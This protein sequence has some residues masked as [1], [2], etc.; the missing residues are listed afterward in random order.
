MKARFQERLVRFQEEWEEERARSL[1]IGW[2]RVGTFVAGLSGYVVADVTTGV[3]SRTAWV[4][5]VLVSAAFLL[6]VVWHRRIRRKEK[7]L[8]GLVQANGQAL[9]R[10]DRDWTTLPDSPLEPPSAQHPYALDLDVS[11]PGSLFSLLSTVTLPPGQT[12]LREWLLAPAS[13]DEIRRRQEGVGELAPQLDLRQELEVTGRGVTPPGPAAVDRF[14]DWAEGPSWL[15]EHLAIRVGAWVL[16]ILNLCLVGM[17]VWG[18]VARP[19]WLFSVGMTF[20]VAGIHRK[21]IH[22]IMHAAASGQ[23]GLEPYADLLEILRDMDV[24]API[25]QELRDLARSG[26]GGGPGEL[27]RLEKKIGWANVRENLLVHGPF[28]GLFAWD[29]HALSG[30]EGWKDRSGAHVRGWLH[31]LGQL[32]ALSAL[33]ALKGEHPEWTFPR[34]E[35][36][37]PPGLWARGLGHP[38]LPPDRCVVN[39]VSI[40]PPGG[41]LF[42]T[43]SNMSGKSTLLRAVGL[44]V[45]LAQA[46][47]PV[48]AREMR[49]TPLDVETSMRTAD[50]LAQGVSQYMAE[51]RRIE[52]VVRAARRRGGSGGTSDVPSHLSTDGGGGVGGLPVLYLLDE[53][54][55]GTNE[56]ERRVAVQTI[57]GHLLEAGAVGAVATHDLYLDEA[58]G[59]REAADAVHLEGRVEEGDGGPLLRFDFKL[60]EGR[61][62]STNALALLRAVGL[63]KAES[64]RDQRE[65]PQGSSS[66]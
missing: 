38:L 35:K 27:R 13:P 29:I 61:A 41:F 11:G 56:A 5:T 44:N 28:Q 24:D 19:W 18:F 45:V 66:R 47:G 39:E 31:A 42:L 20:I 25:L 57:L 63:G 9:A 7:R 55:Q 15:P 32:E 30:L 43:G 59:L 62:T 53:P 51:L 50:S 40:G 21:D 10:L 46:G 49:L 8:A 60:R 1:R 52:Q 37:A 65:R 17:H 4:A 23:E 54:L 12:V 36:D 58:E 14:L 2:F 48:C 16:P 26:P 6:E 22:R 64:P 34:V 3:V 33:A